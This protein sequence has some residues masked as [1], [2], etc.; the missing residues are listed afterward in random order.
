MDL[1][2]VD[3]SGSAGYGS[4]LTFTLGCVVVQSERWPDVF[5]DFID[6]RRFIRSRFGVPVRAEIKANYLLHNGG[7]F[8]A[9]PLGENARFAIYRAHM[10]L[11]A[12]LG[13]RVFA[14]VVKKDDLTAAGV[15]T[16][17][18]AI[19]W[20]Y[21]LQR[22]E[23]MSTKGNTPVML[24]H[25]EGEA[26]LVRSYARK[27][28]RAGTAGSALGTGMLRRPA[29]L[30]VDDPVPRQSHQS[31]FLQAA[32][33]VAYAAF[34]HVYPP[35]ARGRPPVVTDKTWEELGDARFKPVSGFKGGP[36]GLVIYP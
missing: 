17:P 7:P 15:T 28:R 34:R 12:K 26:L 11:M 2:Y 32:D 29:R 21:L 5:D 16:D 8:R 6:F 10:R 30:L 27:A 4:S 1:A 25:D 24:I 18:R 14:V 20:E 22:L 31:Y 19:A 35:P 33:L 23:R 13:L 36:D 3:E 9:H